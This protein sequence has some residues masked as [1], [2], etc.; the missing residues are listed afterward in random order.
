VH[1]DCLAALL[2]PDVLASARFRVPP[3][4]GVGHVV[5][6]N[7]VAAAPGGDD[8]GEQHAHSAIDPA[9]LDRFCGGEGL[10]AEVLCLLGN[11]RDEDA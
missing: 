8:V 2:V 3:I 6:G 4:F 7:D 11:E 10:K 9:R 1:P 5:V